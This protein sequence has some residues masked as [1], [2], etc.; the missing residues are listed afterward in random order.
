MYSKSQIGQCALKQI[1]RNGSA[2]QFRHCSSNNKLLQSHVFRQQRLEKLKNIN[3]YPHYFSV[4][5]D[6]KQFREKYDFL[7]TDK[8]SAVENLSGMVTGLR[9]Y[10][11]KLKFVDLERSGYS[12]QLKLS[13]SNFS[14]DAEFQEVTS[15]LNLGDRIGRCYRNS[16]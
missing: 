8:T 4:T 13:R 14:N 5:S 12:V 16:G 2:T 7:S 11:K 3:K 15:M 6:L 9:D 10:G 1:L